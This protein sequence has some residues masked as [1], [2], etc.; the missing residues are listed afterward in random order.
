MEH[1]SVA[2]GRDKHSNKR[3]THTAPSGTPPGSSSSPVQSS[4]KTTTSTWPPRNSTTQAH[5]TTGTPAATET[6]PGLSSPLH[7]STSAT[8]SHW[9]FG[10]S[11][12]RRKPSPPSPSPSASE[13]V[14][15]V[16]GSV[17]L[18]GVLVGIVVWRRVTVARGSTSRRGSAT[19]AAEEDD[20]SGL[21]SESSHSTLVQQQISPGPV[22]TKPIAHRHRISAA[23]ASPATPVP[24]GLG[25][26]PA[27]PLDQG[28]DVVLHIYDDT[29]ANSVAVAPSTSYSYSDDTLVV[30]HPDSSPIKPP[31]LPPARCASETGLLLP[32]GASATGAEPLP[33]ETTA[34]EDL[35][36]PD[37]YHISS[38][39]DPHITQ[40]EEA[41]VEAAPRTRARRVTLTERASDGGVRLAGGLPVSDATVTADSEGV[42]HCPG[43]ELLSDSPDG[44]VV[45]IVALPPPYHHYDG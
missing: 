17:A 20:S 29:E 23:S 15:I 27:A 11:R 5:P 12:P 34:R 21:Q 26:G 41:H 7:R 18:V 14:G 43:G 40:T 37:M 22:Y 39:P 9:R 42:E 35:Q 33:A 8:I 31:G 32:G 1:E 44:S 25:S 6:V 19:R 13:I 16:L 30:L 24:A 3:P 45:E 28:G 38:E 10:T 2:G 36:S 4:N